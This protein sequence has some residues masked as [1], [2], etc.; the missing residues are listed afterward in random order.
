[1]RCP[2]CDHQSSRVV[3]SR[4]ARENLAIRRRRECESC[5]ERF[6]TYEEGEDVQPSVI[7]KDKT[8]QPFDRQKLQAGLERACEKRPVSRDDTTAFLDRLEASLRSSGRRE[9]PTREIG[10]EIFDLLVVHFNRND[11]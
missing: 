11:P 9:I 3:D 8:R 10:E 4:N 7:K 6:T 2:F 1:M 5:K